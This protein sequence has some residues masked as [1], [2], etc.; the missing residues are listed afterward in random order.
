MFSLERAK[1]V[2]IDAGNKLL[3][4]CDKLNL[5][6]SIRRG[7]RE[8]HD[9]EIVCLPKMVKAGQI[10]IFSNQAQ[11]DQVHPQFIE[12][13]LGLGKV[14]KGKPDGRMMQIELKT[15][16]MPATIM[17]DLFMPQPDDYIR[18]YCIRTGSAKYSNKVIAEGWRKIGWVGTSEGLRRETE[19]LGTPLPDGKTKWKC[20]VD[21]PTLPPV[22]QSE[23]EF[24][25]WLGVQYIPPAIRY[26]S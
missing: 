20:I 3:P 8:V 17:L 16:H 18:I 9:I 2:A 19:C 4:F 13:V 7:C 23:E 1:K 25:A 26:V 14:V 22:W 11:Q 5:A 21:N 6:G 10:D 12:T 24:F 15:G